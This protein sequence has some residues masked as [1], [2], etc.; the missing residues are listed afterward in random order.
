MNN[1][2]VSV[3]VPVHNA[4]NYLPLCLESIINQTLKDI[5]IICVND[6][7]TDNTSLVLE[8]YVKRDSRI[9]VLNVFCKCSGGARNRGLDI[10]NGEYIGFVDADDRIEPDYFEKLYTNAKFNDSDISATSAVFVTNKFKKTSLKNVGC[11]SSDN[12]VDSI[13][14]KAKCILATGICWNKI[15]RSNFLRKNNIKFIEIHNPAE[16]NYFSVIAIILSNKITFIDDAKYHY[17]YTEDSQTQRIKTEKDFLI[18]DIFKKILNRL[19][20]FCILSEWENVVKERAFNNILS[21]YNEYDDKTKKNFLK[22]IKRTFPAF[23]KKIKNE[24]TFLE[25]VFSLKNADSHKVIRFLGIKI[26]IKYFK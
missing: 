25:T 20:E 9:K 23:S 16:D 24:P 18:V 22:Y 10:A 1:L 21:F 8:S 2:K 6:S 12:P 19:S 14:K 7:S 5:E 15:Y 11:T 26:K 17:N 4:Q 3:I 13:E